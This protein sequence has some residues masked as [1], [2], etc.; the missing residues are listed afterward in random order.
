MTTPLHQASSSGHSSIVQLLLSRRADIN[1]KD[2]LGR[3]AL[4]FA[5]SSPNPQSV[6]T[7]LTSDAR[8]IDGKDYTG[9]SALHYAIFNPHP[10]QVEIIRKLLE[11]GIPADIPDSDNKTPLHHACEAGKTRSIRILLK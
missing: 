7:L 9:R 3:T 4:L 11:F 8:I 6:V 10:K 5:V 1:A 2:N